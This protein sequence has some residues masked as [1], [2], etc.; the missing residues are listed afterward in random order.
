VKA[1]NFILFIQ[2][3]ITKF[4]KE[5]SISIKPIKYTHLLLF[6][7][8]LETFSIL[9]MQFDFHIIL[10]FSLIIQFVL[11]YVLYFLFK[12]KIKYKYVLLL[13]QV[14]LILI[15]PWYEMISTNCNIVRLMKLNKFLNF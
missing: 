5:G 14:N 9:N 8:F 15:L 3:T 4:L 6:A 10:L 2:T 12:L 1:I 7:N 11:S 13:F